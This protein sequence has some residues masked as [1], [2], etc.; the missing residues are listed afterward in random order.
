MII[1][2]F[3]RWMYYL[4]S[5]KKVMKKF[6][7]LIVLSCKISFNLNRKKVCCFFFLLDYKIFYV[8]NVNR[9]I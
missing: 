4:G 5:W 3:K 1:V 6:L 7:I 2:K 9:I 8:V